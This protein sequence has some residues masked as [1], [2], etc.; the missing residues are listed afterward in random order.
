MYFVLN[1]VALFFTFVLCDAA[2]IGFIQSRLAT[3][4]KAMTRSLV[5]ICVSPFPRFTLVVPPAK[6]RFCLLSYLHLA[7]RWPFGIRSES[8]TR[9]RPM[10]EQHPNPRSLLK[11]D[12][13]NLFLPR[14][15]PQLPIRRF[16]ICR[17][18]QVSP[19]PDIQ[20][21]TKASCCKPPKTYSIGCVRTF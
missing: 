2:D 18:C 15:S 12:S 13:L 20:R 3:T 5:C 10:P 1:A 9:F 21:T 16:H 8:S 7:F 14:P 6:P 4:T 19:F 11:L 17:V